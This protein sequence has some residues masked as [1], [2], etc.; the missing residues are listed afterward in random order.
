MKYLNLLIKEKRV[1]NTIK[2]L[3]YVLDLG[4][5]KRLPKIII[6]EILTDSAS[7]HTV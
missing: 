1:V 4:Q 6:V 3:H 2:N 7:I 5:A